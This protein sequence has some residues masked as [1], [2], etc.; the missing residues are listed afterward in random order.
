MLW[1]VQVGSYMVISVPDARYLRHQMNPTHPCMVF[2]PSIP[3]HV[4]ENCLSPRTSK[5]PKSLACLYLT[6]QISTETCSQKS[7]R[8]DGGCTVHPGPKSGD[9]REP[10]GRHPLCSAHED[11]A[12]GT[13]R[14]FH[15]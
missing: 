14:P 15:P 4:T 11:G 6:L 9:Q 2:K 7:N 13:A 10:A 5:G 3:A 1:S 12:R 8:G